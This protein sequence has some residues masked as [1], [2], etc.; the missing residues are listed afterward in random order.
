MEKEKIKP[1]FNVGDVICLNESIHKNLDYPILEMVV[2]KIMPS[3]DNDFKVMGMYRVNG[4]IYNTPMI[5]EKCF[6]TP[7]YKIFFKYDE[8]KSN[9]YSYIPQIGDLVS[10]KPSTDSHSGIMVV[11]KVWELTD[12]DGNTYYDVDVIWRVG[13][14]WRTSCIRR[15][16]LNMYSEYE[17][18]DWV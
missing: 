15:E 16:C 14:E 17:L 11:T 9:D 10:L 8:K 13:L 18:P 3:E 4:E 2:T 6:R 7:D 5:S 12:I 1:R